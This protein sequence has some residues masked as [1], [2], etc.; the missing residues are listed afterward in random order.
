[1]QQVFELDTLKSRPRDTLPSLRKSR[2]WDHLKEADRTILEMV[3][4]GLSHRL[5]GQ[6]IGL[7]AGTV[8]R[9]ISLIKARL[10]SPL[11]RCALDPLTP[12]SADIRQSAVLHAV[13]G[14]SLREVAR[15]R[16]LSIIAVTD[17]VRFAQ[18]VARATMTRRGALV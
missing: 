2:A 16:R 17:H 11:A 9:R 5:I 13:T 4:K 6:A 12:L 18:G 8:S 15:H 7:N 14:M 1:M 10:Q 3:E